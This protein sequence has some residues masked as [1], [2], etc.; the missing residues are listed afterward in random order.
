MSEILDKLRGGDLRSIGRSEEVVMD[1]LKNS[2]LMHR[3]IEGMFDKDPVVRARSADASEKIGRM[4][5]DYLQNFKERILKDA[6]RVPQQEV[7]WHVAQMISYL[8]L[9]PEETRAAAKILLSWLG[10]KK[11]KSKIVRVSCLQT[12]T[13]LGVRQASL[14][15]EVRREIQR[16]LKQ[17]TPAEKS[18][19]RKLDKLLQREICN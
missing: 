7:R 19:A 1:V 6:S 8:D 17:G 12:L 16:A 10:D 9:T 2:A 15:P 3:L 5:R 13:E 11:C 18:R 14:L 4:R